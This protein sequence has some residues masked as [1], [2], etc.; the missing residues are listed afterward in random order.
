MIGASEAAPPGRARELRWRAVIGGLGVLAGL[1]LSAFVGDPDLGWSI[2]V[3]FGVLGTWAIVGLVPSR[4]RPVAAILLAIAVTSVLVW[5]SP[6]QGALTFWMNHGVLAA[7]FMGLYCLGIP[8]AFVA[9]V[10][11]AVSSRFRGWWAFGAI[12]LTAMVVTGALA[13]MTAT[14]IRIR[15]LTHV[16]ELDA[17]ADLVRASGID[18]LFGTETSPAPP[19]RRVEG[20]GDDRPSV[21]VPS[22]VQEVAGMAVSG[23]SVDQA[24]GRVGLCVS[25]HPSTCSRELVH[26]P[27]SDVDGETTLVNMDCDTVVHHLVD[28]WYVRVRE[29]PRM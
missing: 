26:S 25:G 22:P 29:C 5:V 8:V 6:S 11:A 24:T 28:D 23:G 19:T 12:M 2:A 27:G 1:A 7:V 14:S 21:F 18:G 10:L 13:V 15:A 4:F 20:L 16:G 9:L 3:A 17:T